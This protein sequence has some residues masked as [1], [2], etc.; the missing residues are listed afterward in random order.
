MRKRIFAF[1]EVSSQR[2]L[3]NCKGKK[4]ELGSREIFKPHKGDGLVKIIS[5]SEMQMDVTCLQM[6]LPEKNTL[7][8]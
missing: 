2:P 1:L 8:P 5:I 6:G 3:T 4:C 7:L